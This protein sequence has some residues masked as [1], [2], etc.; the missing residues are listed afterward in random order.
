MLVFSGNQLNILSSFTPI[1]V[2]QG[3]NDVQVLA[4]I[5]FVIYQ[6]LLAGRTNV[7]FRLYEGLNHLFMPSTTNNIMALM[8][9]FAIESQID[10][11][12]LADIAEW[13]SNN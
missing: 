5:D 9:E 8:D 2:M 3:A 13:V 12:V 1:L 6:E 4:D 7:T 10:S 11:Q